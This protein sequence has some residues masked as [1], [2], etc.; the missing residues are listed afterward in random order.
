MAKGVVVDKLL[1]K[2]NSSDSSYM[3]ERVVVAGCHSTTGREHV[4][5]ETTIPSYDFVIYFCFWSFIGILVLIMQCA[6]N[7]PTDYSCMPIPDRQTCDAFIRMNHRVIAMMFVC[8]SV[9]DVH[10]L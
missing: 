3:P 5:R 10:A 6:L 4:L 9:W 7:K 8:L 1:I 2:V